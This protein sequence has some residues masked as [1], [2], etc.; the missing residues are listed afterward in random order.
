MSFYAFDTNSPTILYSALHA[1]NPKY[2][3]SVPFD[4]IDIKSHNALNLVELSE[5]QQTSRLVQSLVP[6][7]DIVPQKH[8][9]NL[10][11]RQVL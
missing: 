2:V 1:H 6:R 11:A 4:S 3:C 8:P 9:A 10:Y 5:W 7:T